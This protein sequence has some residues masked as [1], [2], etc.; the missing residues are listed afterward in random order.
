MRTILYV[1][2]PARL[3]GGE[4]SLLT[5]VAGLPRDRYRPVIVT[6]EDGELVERLRAM[7]VDVEVLRRGPALIPRLARLIRRQE[8]GLVHVNLFDL[9]AALA[10][11]WA[12]VPLI[13]HLRVIFPFRWPDRLFVR[14]CDRTIAVSDA[15]RDHFCRDAPDLRAR[16]RTAYNARPSSEPSPGSTP[17]RASTS[18]SGPRA[19]F[20]TTGPVCDSS[21]QAAPEMPRRRSRTNGRSAV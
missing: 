19:A 10:A 12:G 13:G 17:G 8:A 18:S 9:R 15:V 14:L 6:Y 20:T 3:G 4:I 16:F 11:R 5:L 1:S 2:P 7:G 21:S